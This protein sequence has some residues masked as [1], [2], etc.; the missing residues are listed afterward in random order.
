MT[1]DT[2]LEQAIALHRQGRHREAVINLDRVVSATPGRTDAWVLRGRIMLERG[3]CQDALTSFDRALTTRPR[4]ATALALRGDALRLLAQ[5]DQALAAYRQA[6]GIDPGHTRARN[7]MG[8]IVTEQGHPQ[9]GLA[10]HDSVL[11]LHPDFAEA[12]NG[13]GLALSRLDDLPRAL[14]S[15]NRALTLW[16]GYVDALVNA[17]NTL[18]RM[19]RLEEAL[20]H[21]Q[22]AL[23]LDPNSIDALYSQA[24]VLGALGRL[25]EAVS[26]C[27]R[28]LA[29]DSGFAPMN[30]RRATLL[31]LQ[32]RH[33]EAVLCFDQVLALPT[34]T[35][36]LHAKAHVLRGDSLRQL[37]RLTEAV[38]TYDRVIALRPKFADAWVGRGLALRNLGEFDDAIDHFDTAL[39][40][41]P[42]HID[43]RLSRAAL[44]A[45]L[46]RNQESEAEARLI[47]SIDPNNGA[48]YNNLG[49][50][51]QRLGRLPEAR[52]SFETAIQLVPDPTAAR[53]N[54]GMCLLQAGDFARGWR[55]YEFRGKTDGWEVGWDL[56]H[57]PAW[58]GEKPIAGRTIL[59]YAEQ[60][61]GDTIQFCRYAPMVRALGAKVL[62]G[63]PPVL[64]RLTQSLDD[65]IEVIDV[66]QP[67]PAFDFHCSIM[68]L[69]LVFGTELATIPAH[70]PYLTAPG[71]YRTK[72][73]RILGPRRSPRIGLAWSGN[74]KPL[75]RSIPLD[76]IG[77]LVAMLP[78][79]FCLQRDL[80]PSDVPALAMYQGIRF[81]GHDLQDFS[82][83]AA[84]MQ[85]LDL[86]ISI[87]T[88]VLHLA[89][90]LGLPAWGMMPYAADWRWL[91]D[92]EDSPWYPTM[93]LFR[94]PASGDWESIIDRL[95]T[96]LDQYL[97]TF[98]D[99]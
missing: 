29:I 49:N 5:H 19:G 11:A 77:P 88:S 34:E 24:G 57:V 95:C 63:V 15:F 91:M 65:P 78:E 16:P 22:Q 64:K 21:H 25:D 76:T 52:E 6:A 82:D 85:E 58:L 80:R 32:G 93:R 42:R 62:L 35:E 61:L 27:D 46:G 59:L 41:N 96:E 44:L 37:D 31:A 17:G 39:E 94:P 9:Q 69:P 89:G 20:A 53:F 71:E 97:Q 90:A 36:A 83:T 10:L 43:A 3:A 7:G 81:F 84:L 38:A 66:D 73:Q 79:V 50:A 98:Q 55:E 23:R 60:G 12:H 99:R 13:R 14:V 75:G 86:I 45:T 26:Q 4:D 48:A 67:A 70:V 54:Y 2:L 68:S 92:R 30:M 33:A 74:D 51:L 72:W 47:L 56:T 28:A 87:D 18:R 1:G 8:L 40:F